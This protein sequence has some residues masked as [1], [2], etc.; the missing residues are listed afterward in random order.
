VRI[1]PN[2]VGAFSVLAALIAGTAGATLLFPGTPLDVIWAIRSDAVHAQMLALGW[3][4]GAGLWLV[5]LV[6]IATALGSFGRRR[7]AWWI[8]AVGM[9]ANC[10]SD[11]VRLAGGGIIEGLLG[12]LIAG[13]ILFWLTRPKVRAEFSR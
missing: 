13:S 5:A 11:L 3:L 2:L 9:I 1:A 12:L 7:W 4:A 8:A 6:A 10:L